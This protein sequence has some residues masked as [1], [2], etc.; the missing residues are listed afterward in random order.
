LAQRTLLEERLLVGGF[1][2]Q[3]L[4]WRWSL[5]VNLVFAAVAVTGVLLLLP[6]HSGDARPRLNLRGTLTGSAGLFAL[7]YGFSR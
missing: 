3:Y 4:S 7:V 5:Y 6:T 2:T 1:L